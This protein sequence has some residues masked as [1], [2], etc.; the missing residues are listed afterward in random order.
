LSGVSRDRT[1]AGAGFAQGVEGG[2]VVAAGGR[3]ADAEGGGDVA[4]RVTLAV[5]EVDEALRALGQR[6]DGVREDGVREDG[7][8]LGGEDVRF[9]AG[10]RWRGDRY[11]AAGAR[12]DCVDASGRDGGDAHD[13]RGGDPRG[14]DVRGDRL[15][16]RVDVDPTVLQIEARRRAATQRIARGRLAARRLGDPACDAAPRERR[17]RDAALGVDAPRRLW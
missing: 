13:G 5:V 11:G 3:A 7:A 14:E 8:E 10:F 6:G 15:A 1:R 16:A 12:R 9:G 4:E 2:V 17:E